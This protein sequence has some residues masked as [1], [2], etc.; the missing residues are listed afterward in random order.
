MHPPDVRPPSK[1]PLIG[2]VG[3][4][5]AGKTTL[6]D[7]LRAAGFNAHPIAQEH[8]FVPEMW[9][10]IS[11]PALLIFL[12][13]SYEVCTQRK[14]LDWRREE[15]EEELRRLRHARRECDH[16]LNSDALDAG[17]VLQQILTHIISP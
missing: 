2:I 7:G 16:Y 3:P 10:L 15:Y 5:G 13:A 8:S 6:A 1:N 14:R 12:D 17:Q 9:R 4:C 11:N